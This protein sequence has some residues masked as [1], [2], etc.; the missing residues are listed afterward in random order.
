M[1][2][3]EQLDFAVAIDRM[4][5]DTQ[6]QLDWLERKVEWACVMVDT[7]ML[8][9]DEARRAL[10]EGHARAIERSRACA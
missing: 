5:C 3:R 9:L 7:G 8:P 4:A 6:A 2:T 10:K 1:N